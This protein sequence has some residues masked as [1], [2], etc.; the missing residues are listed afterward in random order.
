KTSIASAT[1][2]AP[3]AFSSGWPSRSADDRNALRAR[4]A[5]AFLTARFL[6]ARGGSSGAR[7]L[8]ERAQGFE[9]ATR[10]RG[11]T[12]AAFLRARAWAAR[13]RSTLGRNVV[14]IGTAALFVAF[15]SLAA[16]AAVIYN[17]W[18]ALLDGKTI[19]A[20]GIPHHD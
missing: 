16:S 2:E 19:A 7:C 13:A 1:S 15:C 3:R 4:C 20:T 18:L 8:S 6:P 17:T 14:L 9:Q 11:L 10:A 5:C 12:G